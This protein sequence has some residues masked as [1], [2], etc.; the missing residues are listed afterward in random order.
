MMQNSGDGSCESTAVCA[1]GLDSKD[2]IY[3]IMELP[4]RNEGS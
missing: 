1:A 2:V 4:L 3:T